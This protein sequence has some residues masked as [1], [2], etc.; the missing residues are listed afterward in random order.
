MGDTDKLDSSSSD[1]DDT[2]E[3]LSRI[4]IGIGV[5]EVARYGLHDRSRY[6]HI[7]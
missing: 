2:S 6:I 5:V 7:K 3:S 4:D 1:M